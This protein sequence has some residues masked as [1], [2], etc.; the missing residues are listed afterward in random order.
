MGGGYGGG[1]RRRDVYGMIGSQVMTYWLWGVMGM[2]LFCALGKL[3]V[4]ISKSGVLISTPT[5]ESR[6]EPSIAGEII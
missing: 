2:V 5:S 1:Q 6:R 3:G 4:C